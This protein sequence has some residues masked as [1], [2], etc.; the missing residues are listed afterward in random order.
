[1]AVHNGVSEDMVRNSRNGLRK[2]KRFL[3]ELKVQPYL[4]PKS[5]NQRELIRNGSRF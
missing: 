2:L 4:Q 1:M 3:V 5:I